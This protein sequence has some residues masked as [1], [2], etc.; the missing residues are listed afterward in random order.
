MEGAG[1]SVT[2][3][4]TCQTIRCHIPEDSN[5]LIYNWLL[6][7]TMEFIPFTPQENRNKIPLFNRCLSF[8]LFLSIISS[9]IVFYSFSK[10]SAYIYSR[11]CLS[12][13]TTKRIQTRLLG[14]ISFFFYFAS[15]FLSTPPLLTSLF[16]LHPDQQNWAFRAWIFRYCAEQSVYWAVVKSIHFTNSIT[17]CAGY[18]NL[19]GKV[20]CKCAWLHHRHINT[21][22]LLKIESSKILM[23]T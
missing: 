5:L 18:S 11:M 23:M 15:S 12:S 16:S 10:L 8:P 14:F 7:S 1:S 20:L 17:S 6:L 22:S 21:V 4:T 9:I 3:V 13:Y 19:V 2:L